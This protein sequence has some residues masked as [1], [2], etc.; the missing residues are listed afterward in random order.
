MTSAAVPTVAEPIGRNLPPD[1]LRR[2][3]GQADALAIRHSLKPA[4]AADVLAALLRA[5]ELA[6]GVQK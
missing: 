6:K 1:V 5:Y 4:A 2:A 3:Q